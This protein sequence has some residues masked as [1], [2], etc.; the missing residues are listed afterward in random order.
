MFGVRRKTVDVVGDAELKY[1]FNVCRTSPFV[2]NNPV[3]LA[4]ADRV[5]L[6][7]DDTDVINAYASCTG[8]EQY[9]ICMNQGIITW[10]TIF[11]IIWMKIDEGM[12]VGKALKL[13]EWCK[14]NSDGH[15]PVSIIEHFSTENN[16][17]YDTF[18]IERIRANT[19]NMVIAVMAHELGHICL[20]H[21]VDDG[22]DSNVMS[23]NRNIERAADLFA[24]SVIQMTNNVNNG[25][26]GAV[27]LEISLMCLGSSDG[28]L[29]H[30]AAVERLENMFTSYKGQF[31]SKTMSEKVL[32]KLAGIK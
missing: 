4:A 11:G 14:K 30:P 10:S 32:R 20:A 19:L 28:S 9:R 16:L 26:I 15:A 23:S 22:Y 29:T 31:V 18:E 17:S 12:P 7:T 8:K 6:V 27:M 2:L 24:A 13:I 5:E 1:A 3:Y 21:V 25:A